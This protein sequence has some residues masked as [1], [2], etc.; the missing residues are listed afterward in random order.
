MIFW[1]KFTVC[2]GKCKAYEKERNVALALSLLCLQSLFLGDLECGV[3]VAFDH[4]AKLSGRDILNDAAGFFDPG[5]EF[6]LLY[7]SDAADE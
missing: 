4:G 3:F 6:C 1:K 7:T 5:T 2:D